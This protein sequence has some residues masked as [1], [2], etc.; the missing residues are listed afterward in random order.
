M[1]GFQSSEQGLEYG[2]YIFTGQHV[3]EGQGQAHL[4]PDEH[5]H[6]PHG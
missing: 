2:Q 5:R 3:M 1:Q 6:W 4:P